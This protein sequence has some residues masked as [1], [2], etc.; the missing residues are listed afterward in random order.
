MDVK[1]KWSY[2]KGAFSFS[3]KVDMTTTKLLAW[4][5]CYKGFSLIELIP[6]D[7]RV[8]YLTTILATVTALYGIKKIETHY[9][10]NNEK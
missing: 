2:V 5:I 9:D 4:F 8:F 3:L 1:E 7:G 10:R 6:L